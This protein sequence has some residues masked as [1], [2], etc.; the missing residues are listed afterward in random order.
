MSFE[1]IPVTIIIGFISAVVGFFGG[2]LVCLLA[3]LFT[4]SREKYGRRYNFKQSQLT[5]LYAPLLAKAAELVVGWELVE[6]LFLDEQEKRE[7]ARH[8]DPESSDRLHKPVSQRHQKQYEEQTKKLAE[9]ST[10]ATTHFELAEP[11]TKRLL[12]HLFRFVANFDASKEFHIPIDATGQR[13]ATVNSPFPAQIRDLF[14]DLET[15]YDRLSSELRSGD[16]DR[17]N[18]VVTKSTKSILKR[19]IVAHNNL[20]AY[21]K[22]KEH[23]SMRTPANSI[24]DSVEYQIPVFIKNNGSE[25]VSTFYLELKVPEFFLIP[26]VTYAHASLPE[27]GFRTFVFTHEDR[28][29]RLEPG[30]EAKICSLAV[31]LTRD[32]FDAGRTANVLDA[33]VGTMPANVKVIPLSLASLNLYEEFAAPMVIRGQASLVEDQSP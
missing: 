10:I 26:Q 27:D 30:K 16:L 6:Q 4:V 20:L 29:I 14:E 18:S 31:R 32:D 12:K 22:T 23:P 7:K 2:I 19:P 8:L 28:L 24:A 21:I 3:H 9:M 1:Q 17:K 5:N 33:V 13:I 25:P 11:S 15:T